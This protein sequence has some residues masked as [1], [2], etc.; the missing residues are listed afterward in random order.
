VRR[1]AQGNRVV[2]QSFLTAAGLSVALGA[3]GWVAAPWLLTLINAAPEMRQALP[4]LR[5]MFAGIVGLIMF[6]MLSARSAPRDPRTPLRL[7]LA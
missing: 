3:V 6:F 4:F 2:Y 1:P 7:G 5:T